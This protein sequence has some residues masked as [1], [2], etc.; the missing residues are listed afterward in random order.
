MFRFSSPE[1]HARIMAWAVLGIASAQLA[2]AA[3]NPAPTAPP[4]RFRR[5]SL[6]QI[7]PS[8]TPLK[9]A[10]KAEI[11]LILHDKGLTSV[12][13]TQNRYLDPEH[14]I[15][16]VYGIRGGDQTLPVLYRPDGSAYI[17]LI[18]LRMGE[19]ELTVFGSFP[20]RAF[21]RNRAFLQVVPS[22]RRPE[23]LIVGQAGMPDSDTDIL[24]LNLDDSH[25][26]AQGPKQM[27]YLYPAAYY[28]DLHVPIELDRPYVRSTVKQPE[29]DPVIEFD[30]ASGGM[31][32]LR[33][34]AALV[35]NFYGGLVKRTCVLVRV[36]RDINDDRD[37]EPLFSAARSIVTAP[38]DTTWTQ[39]PYGM[40]NQHMWGVSEFPTDRLEVT[41]PDRPVEFAQP[42]EIPVKTSDDKVIY[43]TVAQTR[44]GLTNYNGRRITPG[45]G[46]A[47]PASIT[48]V[49][50]QFDDDLV[51]ITAHFRDH[52]VAQRYFRLNVT[53]S[54]KGLKR[55]E[56]HATPMEDGYLRVTATL[57]YEQLKD[58]VQLPDLKRM[59]YRIDQGAIP[60]VLRIEPDG[61]IRYVRAG[62]AVIVA[63]FCGVTGG[64]AV[65]VRE[66]VP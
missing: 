10:E 60:D 29:D 59:T 28:L 14:K 22:E 46:D 16:D 35:E 39:N 12:K 32:P 50:L 36:E 6:I 41:P 65:N 21:D 47:P 66:P 20:D 15:R 11:S 8:S 4:V 26:W 7:V 37:C 58:P 23:A 61:R 3:Q 52:G 57:N 19:I 2:A 56:L 55:V 34:G 51:L 5:G 25:P 44:P 43:Y 27:A 53:P 31:K 24:R 33:R 13:A 38:L 62:Q 17:E 45:A 30:Q 63:T 42:V 9:V 40:S 1:S 54:G 49:P 64:V 18:P 48:L